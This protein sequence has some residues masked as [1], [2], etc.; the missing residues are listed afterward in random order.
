MKYPSCFPDRAGSSLSRSRW[1]AILCRA[2]TSVPV[3]D[4]D[5]IAT[6]WVII[7]RIFAM[8]GGLRIRKECE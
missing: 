5:R 7:T 6:Y 4:E 3:V 8:G 2:V 1:L